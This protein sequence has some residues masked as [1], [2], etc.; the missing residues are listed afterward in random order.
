MTRSSVHPRTQEHSV[1]DHR[2]GLDCRADASYGLKGGH[3]MD[4]TV[5]ANDHR[6]LPDIYDMA[7]IVRTSL[8]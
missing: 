6:Y 8:S 7:F 1:H 5:R 2:I 4:A 3:E